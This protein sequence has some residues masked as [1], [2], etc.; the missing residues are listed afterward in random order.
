M[1]EE[2]LIE[3]RDRI[4]IITL[5]RPEAKNSVNGPLADALNA[6]IAELDE[7]PGLTAGVLTGAG[8]GFSSGMDLKWFATKGPP[9]G[10]GQFLQKGAKKPL[11]AAIEGFALAGGLELA[12]TCDLLVAADNVKFGIPE[13]KRGLFAAGGA[14][15]R[16][17]RVIPHGVAMEMALTGDP[18]TAERALELG[19][20]AR[21]SSPGEALGVA[22]DLALV[23]AK[24]AP[25]SVAVSKKLIVDSYGRTEEEFWSHQGPESGKIFASKDAQEGARA[26]AEK[27]DPEWT[28]S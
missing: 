3:R 1:A 6:A 11:I 15:M 13:A 12:L 9:A 18:I 19:L 10:F 8:G 26:F 25:L 5:N 24:N 22:I 27:R 4:M 20:I 16:L 14:L 28:G 21:L 17:P 2:I 7:D 23:I